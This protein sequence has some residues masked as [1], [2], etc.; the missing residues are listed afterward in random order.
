MS[1]RDCTGIG[2]LGKDA[3]DVSGDLHGEHDY[4]PGQGIGAARM[5][6]FRTLG[7]WFGSANANFVWI[8]LLAYPSTQDT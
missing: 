1:V 2:L 5:P 4:G 8:Y 7:P 3:L 6:A